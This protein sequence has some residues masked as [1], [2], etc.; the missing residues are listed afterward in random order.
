MGGE[1]KLENTQQHETALNDTRRTESRSSDRL[2]YFF[3]GTLDRA[4]TLAGARRDTGSN[5][6]GSGGL[7]RPINQFPDEHSMYG[8]PADVR[9]RP[10][11]LALTYHFYCPLLST[12]I[13]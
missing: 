11:T 5:P 2:R 10:W 6:V 9:G 13:H 7:S 4:L 3:P 1:S 12:T 8:S